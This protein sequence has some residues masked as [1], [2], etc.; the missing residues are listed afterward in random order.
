MFSVTGMCAADNDLLNPYVKKSV[1]VQVA[2]LLM[3]GKYKNENEIAAPMAVLCKW[4]FNDSHSS[5]WLK[6]RSG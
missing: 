6:A 2:E 4:L 3:F 5:I 1:V